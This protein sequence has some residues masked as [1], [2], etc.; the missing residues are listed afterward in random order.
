MTT[1]LNNK[2]K[3]ITIRNNNKNNI[4]FIIYCLNKLCIVVVCFRCSCFGFY[5]ETPLLCDWLKKRNKDERVQQQ[6]NNKKL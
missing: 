5:K 1:T 2:V 3:L 4:S 6:Q